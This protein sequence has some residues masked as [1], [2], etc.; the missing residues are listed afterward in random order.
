MNLKDNKGL[1]FYDFD[2]I[3]DEQDFKQNY[4]KALDNLPLSVSDTSKIIA[5]ANV[6][7]NLN[8]KM[9]QE[10]ETS[11]IKI[12][13]SVSINFIKSLLENVNPK[14]QKSN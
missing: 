2:E 12:F 9:F 4:K 7:F 1:A 11:F 10:L 5:E 13:V 6:T 3:Q 8:M 14:V